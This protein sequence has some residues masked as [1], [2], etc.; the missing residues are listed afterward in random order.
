[1]G[2]TRRI[3]TN[4][5]DSSDAQEGLVAEKLEWASVQQVL[6][7]VLRSRS[8][9]SRISIK[10]IIILRTWTQE[11]YCTAPALRLSIL[12]RSYAGLQNPSP[13]STVGRPQRD[14]KIGKNGVRS[15]C[16]DERLGG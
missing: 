4:P 13:V 15:V 8:S 16:A 10:T 11:F 12:L 9:H 5:V 14:P 3:S 6:C 2:Q 7:Y 1:M